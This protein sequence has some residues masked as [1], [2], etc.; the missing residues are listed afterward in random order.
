M[1]G[2]WYIDLGKL[3]SKGMIQQHQMINSRPNAVGRDYLLRVGLVGSVCSSS[4]SS[5]SSSFQIISPSFQKVGTAAA[6]AIQAYSTTAFK[7]VLLIGLSAEVYFS[8]PWFALCWWKTWEAIEWA[9]T[10]LKQPIF[11]E[12]RNLMRAPEFLSTCTQQLCHLCENLHKEYMK[13]H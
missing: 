10:S 6:V 4:L 8:L 3:S 7:R 13:V 5:S 2:D 11:A 9:P 1:P 12:D